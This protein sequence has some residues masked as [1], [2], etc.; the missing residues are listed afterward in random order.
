MNDYTNHKTT[1]WLGCRAL[2]ALLL[3]MLSLTAPKPEMKWTSTQVE[4]GSSRSSPRGL[5]N[6]LCYAFLK[7]GDLFVRCNGTLIRITKEGNVNDFAVSQTGT[8]M[9]LMRKQDN[10][11]IMNL[12]I[13][14]LKKREEHVLPIG[15]KFGSLVA[16][17]GSTLFLYGT[18]KDLVS[19]VDLDFQPYFDFRCSSNREAIAGQVELNDHGTIVTGLP[20][21]NDHSALASGL[22]PKI[23]LDNS[24]SEGFGYDVSPN[25]E[26][27]AYHMAGELC[28]IANQMTKN[29]V[30][31]T[32]S[33][34]RISVSDGGDIFFT[35]HTARTCRYRDAFHVALTPRPGYDS[36]GP[37]VAVAVLQRGGNSSSIIEPL[38]RY[39]QWLTP[40]AESAVLAW[41]R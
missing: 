27:L 28:L 7:Q 38:A 32:D 1:K 39:P 6:S 37:C 36:Q 29:C 34:N 19:G 33:L 20:T 40:E 21:G 11:P 35:T 23:W 13:I 14:L 16:S 31:Q 26:Y 30:R 25:G 18:R 5:N 4:S 41:R 2:C 12:Q 8:A 3:P 22:P 15:Q 10:R 24:G 17:C 9:V